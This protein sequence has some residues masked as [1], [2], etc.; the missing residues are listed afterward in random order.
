MIA[1]PVDCGTPI[2]AIEGRVDGGD[3]TGAALGLGV[4]LAVIDPSLAYE[5]FSLNLWSCGTP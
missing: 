5:F 1:E 2:V 3:G 4:N